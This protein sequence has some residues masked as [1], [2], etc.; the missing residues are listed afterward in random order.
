MNDWQ[1]RR[2]RALFLEEEGGEGGGS[3]VGQADAEAGGGGEGPDGG[4]V[5]G[6]VI[7]AVEGG[8]IG[9]AT[10]VEVGRRDG[11]FEGDGVDEEGE[12]AGCGVVAEAE[13]H[14]DFV[15]GAPCREEPYGVVV[16][17][18]EVVFGLGFLDGEVGDGRP[19]VEG[20]GAGGVW[21]AAS[22]GVGRHY[23]GAGVGGRLS[24]GSRRGGE[25]YRLVGVGTVEMEDGRGGC[26]CLSHLADVVKGGWMGLVAPFFGAGGEQEQDGEDE[27][28]EYR[29]HVGG[30]GWVTTPSAMWMTRSERE[31]SDSSWVTMTK[32]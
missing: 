7:L 16:P 28:E 4:D 29:F 13:P 15:A 9:G 26:A 31:A 27:G 3:G 20:D 2:S 12:T 1:K 25:D 6:D 10:V 21:F 32:V 17:A 18:L 30:Q 19:A 24:Q 5:D 14:A 23:G 8:S 11:V 22:G